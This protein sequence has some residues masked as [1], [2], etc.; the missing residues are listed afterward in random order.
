MDYNDIKTKIQNTKIIVTGPHFS[1]TKRCAQKLAEDLGY[2][3]YDDMA[4]NG[5]SL[6]LATN[7]I[8]GDNHFVL[9]APG[10]CH[11]AHEL[12]A[13]IIFMV[14]PF[15]EIIID[16]NKYA[17][18]GRKRELMKYGLT[19]HNAKKRAISIVKYDYWYRFQC[20]L[21]AEFY[22]V[23]FHSLER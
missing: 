2:A 12:D 5:D 1:G 11:R 13:A 9:A 18:D 16:E 20:G 7:L 3:Y 4:V 10:L 15:H 17:W 22:E 19:G 14:R 21:C 6:E 23:D 8:K